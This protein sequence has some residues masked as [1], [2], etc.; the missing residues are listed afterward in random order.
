MDVQ[1]LQAQAAQ[2]KNRVRVLTSERAQLAPV[3]I[4]GHDRGPSARARI[5]AIDTERQAALLD[6]ETVEAALAS[7]QFKH[8]ALEDRLE[9]AFARNFTRHQRTL[10]NALASRY[11]QL[12]HPGNLANSDTPLDQVPRVI[13]AEI[14][15][16]T[17]TREQLVGLQRAA[18]LTVGSLGAHSTNASEISRLEA[19]LAVLQ[20]HTDQLLAETELPP[21]PPELAAKLE[22]PP[23]ITGF[24][25]TGAAMVRSRP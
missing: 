2:L 17:R 18:D 1:T 6:L 12:S 11:E 22:E 24:T 3:A 5:A 4:N 21:V 16:E 8:A 14:T 25:I 15:G 23:Q 13:A 19:S 9:N 20:R 7:P 10:V